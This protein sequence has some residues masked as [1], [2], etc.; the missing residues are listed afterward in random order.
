MDSISKGHH[1]HEHGSDEECTGYLLEY[2]MNQRRCVAALE[3]LH[4]KRA[5]VE[6]EFR[7]EVQEL[8]KKYMSKYQPIYTE[9]A[10]LIGGE[11]DPTPEEYGQVPE[12]PIKEVDEKGEAIE[13]ESSV[14]GLPDFW[15]NAL[16]THPAL[17]EMIVDG[18]MP[19][20]SSLKDIR[21]AALESGPGF[22]L[23]FVF[24]KNEFFTNSILTKEYHLAAP[25]S[26]MDDDYV[27]DHAVGCKIAWLAGKNLCFKTVTKTQK[28]KNGRGTRVVKREEPQDSFFHFFD[29]PTLPDEDESEDE[30]DDINEMQEEIEADYEMGD[31]IKSEI[32][33]N[34][35]HWFTGRAL[36]FADYSD[37]YG[38]DDDEEE[39]YDEDSEEGSDEHSGDDSEEDSE[40]D[41]S[42]EEEA[43]RPPKSRGRPAP[44]GKA[45]AA[46]DQQ[47]CK[48][49]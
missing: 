29:P 43:S 3:K 42:S 1:D 33:P 19:A 12:D 4:L 14:K 13:S 41:E 34:A 30:D 22:R 5:E 27:Y 15:L 47:Q 23:E 9:R 21:V 18:D 32:V 6:A 37:Y 28:Q 48:Q 20:L 35:I 16:K 45:G 7:A 10:V 44:A 49:Q 36:D 39:D 31:I 17:S 8:E 2:P 25:T 26:P 38:H 40:D 24:G 46:A 11:R